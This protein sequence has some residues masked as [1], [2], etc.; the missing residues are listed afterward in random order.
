MVNC[1]KRL[2]SALML[3]LIGGAERERTPSARGPVIVLLRTHGA[4]AADG[5]L[6]RSERP[7]AGGPHIVDLRP[8]GRSAMVLLDLVDPDQRGGQLAGG[9]PL[10]LPGKPEAVVVLDEVDQAGPIRHT[11]VNAGEH[12]RGQVVTL[13]GVH[14]WGRPIEVLVLG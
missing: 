10:V 11:G 7:A 1:Q 8:P 4:A 12:D 6:Q 2:P 3:K 5:R 14:A 13:G 9:I